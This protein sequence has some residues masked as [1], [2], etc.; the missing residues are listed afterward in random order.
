MK[1]RRSSTLDSVIYHEERYLLFDELN[2]KLAQ[3]KTC[4]MLEFSARDILTD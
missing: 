3:K 1:T 4:L 2:L